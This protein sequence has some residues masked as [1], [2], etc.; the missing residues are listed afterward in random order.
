VPNGKIVRKSSISPTPLKEKKNSSIVRPKS[1]PA[2][3]RKLTE[4]EMEKM[5]MEMMENAKVRDKE[6]SSNVK[7][8]RKEDKKEEEKQKPYNKDF[9]M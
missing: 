1:P 4:K 3:K 5:R 6:R 9:L 7:R 8:Y 2:K